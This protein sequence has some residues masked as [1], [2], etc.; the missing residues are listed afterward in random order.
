AART[1]LVRAIPVVTDLDLVVLPRPAAVADARGA[2]AGEVATLEAHRATVAAATS[3]R[4][5]ARQHRADEARAVAGMAAATKELS[6]LHAHLAALR[7]E[8]TKA[9]TAHDRLDGLSEAARSAEA[10]ADATDRLVKIRS[11]LAR[12]EADLLASREAA[13]QARS[14][15][16]DLR[17][18]LLD[19]MAAVLAETLVEG[20]ACQVC[21]SSDHPD[22]ATTA[23]SLR[24]G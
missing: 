19:G 10:G 12:A 22:P 4:H 2:I 3:A 5:A 8:I 14:T 15:H 9:T 11:R 18:R 7:A 20:E 21:G 1:A 13:V 17:A 24:S 23:S 16:L 6:Q